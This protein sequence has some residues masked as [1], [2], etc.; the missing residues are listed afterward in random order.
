[1]FV[2]SKAGAASMKGNAMMRF[3]QLAGSSH[4]ATCPDIDAF[5]TTAT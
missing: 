1:M 2:A 4:K 5:G 3:R